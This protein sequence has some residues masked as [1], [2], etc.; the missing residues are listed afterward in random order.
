MGVASG[1]VSAAIAV[2]V[3]ASG[4]AVASPAAAA[5]ALSGVST[6]VEPAIAAP[7]VTA[8]SPAQAQ[9][10]ATGVSV[11]DPELR[12]AMS[13]TVANPNGTYTT[14]VSTVPVNYEDADGDWLPIDSELSE[15]LRVGYAAEN[16][17]NDFNLLVPDDLGSSPIRLEDDQGGWLTFRLIG[18]DGEPVVRDDTAKVPDGPGPTRVVYDS[19]PWGVKETI[20]LP[21]PPTAAPVYKTDL[22]LSPGLSPALNDENEIVVVD[23]EEVER[24]RIRAPYMEDSSGSSEGV[25]TQVPMTLVQTEGGW[26]LSMAPDLAWLQ[27][28]ARVYPVRVDPTTTPITPSTDTY[29]NQGATFTNYSTNTLLRAGSGD[30][31]GLMRTRS[32]LQFPMPS[33]IPTAATVSGGTLS[34]YVV[35]TRTSTATDFAVRRV[36]TAWSSQATWSSSGGGALL[37]DGANGHFNPNLG[38]VRS[39]GG[40]AAGTTQ[41]FNVNDIVA[42]WVQNPGLNR[43]FLIKASSEPAA[44]EIRFASSEAGGGNQPKLSFTWSTIPPTVVT[45]SLAV[46]SAVLTPGGGWRV[47]PG[48]PVVSAR[49]TDPDSSTIVYRFEVRNSTG[50]VVAASPSPAGVP[51]PT[52]GAQVPIS[53]SVP[54]GVL[55]TPGAYTLTVWA[56]DETTPSGA[57]SQLSFTV[58]QAS[59]APSGL[60]VSPASNSAS[61]WATNVLNPQLSALLNDPDSTSLTGVFEIRE[62]G[63]AEVLITGQ[64]SATSGARAT[65]T[66][67][68][69]G[70]DSVEPGVNYE[71]RVGARDALGAASQPATATWSGW[72]AFRINLNYYQPSPPQAAVDPTA[73]Q[74]VPA[75]TPDADPAEAIDDLTPQTMTLPQASTETVVQIGQGLSGTPSTQ[76]RVGSG[77]TVEGTQGRAGT[78]AVGDTVKM[79]VEPS[80]TGLVEGVADEASSDGFGTPTLTVSLTTIQ[81]SGGTSGTVNEDLDLV[82]NYDAFNSTDGD[83]FTPYG[84]H[85]DE[86]L[87]VMAYPAC[88]TTGTPLFPAPEECMEGVPVPAINDTVDGTIAFTSPPPLRQGEAI[89]A[90]PTE[91][92]AASCYQ[93]QDATDSEE[94]LDG[95]PWTATIDVD[96]SAEPSTTDG[97]EADLGD[98]E[99]DDTDEAN[100]LDVDEQPVD[101]TP[102]AEGGEPRVVVSDAP[103]CRGMRFEVSAGV[104]SYGR[105]TAGAGGAAATALKP[106]SSWQV[107]EGSGEFAWSYPFALPPGMGDEAPELALNYSSAAV[108]GM[109]SPEAGQASAAGLGWSLDPGHISRDYAACTQDG[110]KSRGDL[111]W[112]TTNDNKLI[113]D[114]TV[115]LG[116]RATKL[117]QVPTTNEWRL[118]DDPG[119]RVDYNGD[120]TND[121]GMAGNETE[122][123]V[124]TSPDGTRYFFGSN[125]DY[126]DSVW[127]VPVFGNQ[128]GEPCHRAAPKFKNRYCMQ[129]WQWNLDKVAD[130]DGNQVIYSYKTEKNHYQRAS[131]LKEANRT[132]YDRAGRLDKVEYGYTRE[133]LGL[134]FPKVTVQVTSSQ[135]CN[136]ALADPSVTCTET[137]VG[138]RKA[139]KKWPDVPTDLVCGAASKCRTVT[140]SFFSIYRY[141][142][143]SV[144]RSTASGTRTLD[145]YEFQHKMPDPDQTPGKDQPDLWL[146]KIEHLPGFG[147]ST[148]KVPP[149]DFAGIAKQNRVNPGDALP[150]K[151]MRVDSV[152]N[153]MGGR[154]DVEYGHADGRTC[155]AD[156]VTNRK[157]WASDRE[158]FAIKYAPPG[159]AKTPK[160]VWFHKYVVKAITLTDD[161]LGL[162]KGHFP[163]GSTSLATNRRYEFDYLGQPGW[164][165]DNGSVNT[166]IKKRSWTD[167]RGYETTRIKT[168]KMSDPV[169]VAGVKSIRRVTRYRGL[170][171]SRATKY[172]GNKKTFVSTVE[173]A[174]IPTKLEDLNALQGRVAEV[175]IL[176]GGAGD[177]A[178]KWLSR[179]YH[180]YQVVKTAK[181]H[182][183]RQANYVGEYLTR[184]HTRVTR[185]GGESWDR[186]HT[187]ARDLHTGGANGRGLLLGVVKTSKDRGAATEEGTDNDPDVCT[188]TTWAGNDSRWLRVPITE[189]IRD[190][191]CVTGTML[192][193]TDTSYENSQTQVGTSLNTGRPSRVA[194][195]TKADGTALVTEAHYDNFGRLDWTEDANNH[196][197]TITYNAYDN[198]TQRN[199]VVTKIDI[200]APVGQTRT[201]LDARG[202]PVSVKNENNATTTTSYDGYGRVISASSPSHE[203]AGRTSVDYHYNVNATRDDGPSVVE[204]TAHTAA[205][206]SNTPADVVTWDYFDGW[207]RSIETQARHP[208]NSDKRIVTATSYNELGLAAV[209]IPAVYNEAAAGSNFLNPKPNDAQRSTRT[210]YD[211]LGRPTAT[212][213]YA[214]AALKSATILEQQ[215]DR[216]TTLPPAGAGLTV[217]TFDGWGRTK[218]VLQYEQRSLTGDPT[219]AHSATH[220]YTGTG[221]LT[222]IS[223]KIAGTTENWTYGYDLAGRRTSASDPDTGLATYTYDDNGNQLEATDS[224]DVTIKT[225][226]DAMDRPFRRTAVGGPNPGVLVDWTYDTAPGGI[227]K[228]ASVTS[229]THLGDFK[230]TITGYDPDG[231][232]QGTQH[233][234]PANMS[235]STPTGTATY[236]ETYG[237]NGSG[238]LTSTGYEAIGNL[239][240]TTLDYSYLPNTGQVSSITAATPQGTTTLGAHR[241]DGLGR[242]IAIKSVAPANANPAAQTIRNYTWDDATGRLAS[243]DSTRIGKLSYDYDLLGNPVTITQS[244]GSADRSAAW[245]YTYDALNRLKTAR[246]GNAATQA[247]QTTS[248]CTTAAPTSA[249]DLIGVPQNY[250]YSY[251]DDRLMSVRSTST[252]GT[253]TATYRYGNDPEVTGPHQ[254]GAIERDTSAAG[255]TVPETQ[256]IKYDPVG[257]ITSSGPTSAFQTRAYTY[258]P[259][260]T[261]KRATS[262][263]GTLDFAYGAD[264]LRVARKHERPGSTSI[265]VY[266][267]NT[268]LALDYTAGTLTATN[269]RRTFTT[270]A[271]TPLATQRG[272]GTTTSP[273]E[274]AWAFQVGDQQQSVRYEVDATTLS[275]KRS[276]YL[277][278]GDPTAT[279]G[280]DIGRRSYLNKP[281]DPNGDLRLDHRAYDAGLNILTT[282]D[283]LIAA[284]DPRSLNPYAYAGNNPISGSDPSGLLQES[285]ASHGSCDYDYAACDGSMPIMPPAGPG[286]QE[287]ITD[288]LSGFGSGLVDNAQGIGTGATNWASGLALGLSLTG[289]SALSPEV[290]AQGMNYASKRM[291]AGLLQGVI[292]ALELVIAASIVV[293]TARPAGLGLRFAARQMT[294]S[295]LGKRVAAN[296]V[297]PSAQQIIQSTARAEAGKGAEALRGSLS[298]AERA[299]MTENPGLGNAFLGQAVHRNT[300]SALEEAFPGRFWYRTRGP[301]FVDRWTG[302]M[303]ELTTP[304]QV[305]SHLAR[306]GYANVTM[307]TYVVPLC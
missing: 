243:I 294:R 290:R 263:E 161:A 84:G 260:G 43:G 36:D 223:S 119:W 32:L 222:K 26:R 10:V 18:A 125:D 39:L 157:R 123:F 174:D 49:V 62:Q 224:V 21:A 75:S 239:P 285:E 273:Q 120:V 8:L 155:D 179:T 60:Q 300:A 183:D 202:L 146:D 166:P 50:T 248:A 149:V 85:W 24:F 176:R 306:P 144:K 253:S 258:N 150:R 132:A 211:A 101:N 59:A 9:A 244:V 237:Y 128:G 252:G 234:Y 22:T 70:P 92:Q 115:V 255:T 164:R 12:D 298:A 236:T 295:T 214:K 199:D 48:T 279:A 109:S 163:N 74:L 259:T 186:S 307:C 37:W 265:V 97:L 122:S 297:E 14:E 56:G 169:T 19:L 53:Y 45:G 23:D 31:L 126:S 129:G 17:P 276:S 63:S 105:A 142:R 221:L 229:H 91:D 288:S 143:I 87:T 159:S 13:T 274:P 15:T 79:V 44:N 111:C 5:P 80:N 242:T 296:A 148:T 81:N 29:M 198:N 228:L 219:P 231:N 206:G 135:R 158:C 2:V 190:T 205:A 102:E 3:L 193:R 225:E 203:A 182:L 226:Y 6:R 240:A 134:G 136:P 34:M 99:F 145:S 11:E 291:H 110:N 178:D 25:S 117:I 55:S 264:G 130:A 141:A 270:P 261:L 52:L 177:E 173:H 162:S 210:S 124:I 127:T 304:G 83:S 147:P 27:D 40:T 98:G 213:E 227:G 171:R 7:V 58:D 217:Q 218:S 216:L 64:A 287:D 68:V 61:P 209:V 100:E 30:L 35:S 82:V 78:D 71:F 167:W 172:G 131:S 278:F 215:G 138:I 86:R 283:P 160:W 189:T 76:F 51:N 257:R 284:N 188:I 108:D 303:L 305:G 275:E 121:T 289:T 187:I 42:T 277:P 54:A 207:G 88:S 268:E 201:L 66:V 112:R 267:G 197:T 293:P 47:R 185:D 200:A 106:S 281:L 153:E 181:D 116:G 232:A 4:L 96:P 192:A 114:L 280:T 73:E 238:A 137:A 72:S 94:F 233:S 156:Y 272:T 266:L 204:T 103:Y 139:A 57:P 271:G 1:R 220:E 195:W 245:C 301:D 262:P 235:G 38:S 104:G 41:T 165:F 184:T 175:T 90:A 292:N 286:Y 254:T 154:I 299:A 251:T 208:K 118:Q 107:G 250:L 256:T 191:S 269:A 194:T 249:L 170:S 230:T 168:M 196:R 67:P 33:G 28:P 46:S 16:G 65:Y 140:P 212:E 20:V 241:Y 95:D 180:G 113:N 89:P 77:Q 69:T 93:V 152:R 282:P 302:E 247:P 151:K 133:L 246:T